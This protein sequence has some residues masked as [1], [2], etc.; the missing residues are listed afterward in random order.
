M[1][2]SP[3]LDP[4][5]QARLDLAVGAARRAGASTLEWFRSTIAV[6][7]KGDGSP[8]T[9][10]DRRS[11]TLLRDEISASFPDDAILGEEFGE[12]PGTS[13]YRWV[14]D[15]IDGTKSFIAGVPLYTTLVAVLKDEQPLIGVI[16]APATGEIVYAA[17]GGPTWFAV[18]EGTPVLARVSTTEKFAEATFVVTEVNKFNRV[19][20][21]A[22][23]IYDHL[24][25]SCRVT[26]TWG[27]AYGFLLVAT[28]RADIMVDLLINV[29]DLAALLPVIQGA[30]GHFTDWQG[31]PSIRTGNAVATNQ[32]FAEPVL[33]LIRERVG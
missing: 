13:A 7:R 32:H 22:R 21:G 12:K 23:G 20:E 9:A 4:E 24:E 3:I 31:V 14:L 8:V 25:K 26:R 5:T 2:D 28:G 15:P 29:W 17:M 33:K 6:E 30:G 11:E 1:L 16:Y 18:G 19:A 27:D 10:A